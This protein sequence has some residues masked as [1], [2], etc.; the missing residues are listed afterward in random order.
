M[1][2]SFELSFLDRTGTRQEGWFVR[3]NL[4]THY[5]ISNVWSQFTENEITDKEK[6]DRLRVLI[7][8]KRDVLRLVHDSGLDLVTIDREVRKQDPDFDGRA[9]LQYRDRGMLVS[10]SPFFKESPVNLSINRNLLSSLPS[11][12]DIE[13]TR[14]GI[15][16]MRK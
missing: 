3:H 8:R 9:R 10:W 1:W 4:T 7:V 15:S 5:L 11:A 16:S 2:P 6:I 12:C 14:S 13:V